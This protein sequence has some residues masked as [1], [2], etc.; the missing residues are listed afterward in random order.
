MSRCLITDGSYDNQQCSA[1]EV[2]DIFYENITGTSATKVAVKFNCSRRFKCEGVVLKD[3]DI[4]RHHEKNKTQ[5]LCEN[6][7]LTDIGFVAPLCPNAH[8]GRNNTKPSVQ[9]PHHKKN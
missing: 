1:V 8:K 5:A 2:K 7:K 6:V 4:R 9:Q 3:V